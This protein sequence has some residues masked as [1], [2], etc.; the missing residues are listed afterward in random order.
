MVDRDDFVLREEKRGVDGAGNGVGEEGRFIDG[1]HGGFGDFKHEG[2]IGAFF[3]G[4]GGWFV[5]VG[6]L[7]GR[8]T[9]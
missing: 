2:P 9:G 4:G 3:G 7:H 8:E 5:P 6:E 1:F